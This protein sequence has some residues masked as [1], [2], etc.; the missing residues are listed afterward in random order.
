MIS[1]NDERIL[2]DC[3]ASVRN[4]DYPQE[5]ISIKMVDGGSSDRTEAIAAKYNADFIARPDLR[6]RSDVRVGLSLA[7][8][9]TP[10]LFVISADNRLHEPDIISR[11]VDILESDG[12]V[13]GCETAYYGMRPDDPALS[14]YFALIGGND[15]VAVGLGKADRLPL[16]ADSWTNLGQ[17]INHDTFF[18]VTFEP[19]ISKIPTLGANGFMLRSHLISGNVYAETGLHIDMCADLILNGYAT[20]AFLKDRHIIHYIDSTLP[21]F[22]MR[23]VR[24]KNLYSEDKLERLYKVFHPSDLDR[25]LLL[26]VFYGTFLQP[27]IRAGIGYALKPD[28]AWFLHPIVSFV[29]VVSYGV[30]VIRS[31]LRGR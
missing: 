21:E 11:M 26:V 10:Y 8:I 28:R 1:Y 22:L 3:L 6:D 24:F 7:D 25:L 27:L 23:R 18:K 13:V 30:D 17:C 12:S 4:Q 19:E 2:D 31:F 14:R 29:F 5:C 9:L 20:F 16:D 15:S